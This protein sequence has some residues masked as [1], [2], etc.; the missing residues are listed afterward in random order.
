MICTL[1]PV[2]MN[3]SESPNAIT[4]RLHKIAQLWQDFRSVPE[5]RVCRWLIQ[6]D[7]KKMVDAFLETTYLE[8]NPVT[9]FFLPFYTAFT[10][11]E[12]YSMQLVKELGQAVA[13]DKETLGAEGLPVSWAAEQPEE[14]QALKPAYFLR[15]LQL[16]AEQAPAADLLVAVLLPVA[17]NPK[18]SKWINGIVKS[19]IPSNLRLLIVEQVG[20]ELLAT[21][22]GKFPDQVLDAELRLDMPDAMRQLAAAGNPADPGVQF[23][24]AFLELSQAAATRKLSEI[25][26]LEISPLAI[27]RQQGWAPLEIAVHSLVAS[28][29]IGL[30]RLPEAL[31]RYEQGYNLSQKVPLAGQRLGLTLAVQCLFNKG[32]VLIARK[33]FPEAA[34]TFAQAAAHA[35]EVSDHFQ[36]MEAKR[37]QGHCL[38]KCSKW[39]EAFRVEQEAL[40]SAER[41]EQQVRLNSTLP[42]LGRALLDLAYQLGHK[43]RYLELADK[44]TALAGAGW[45]SKLQT[46]KAPAV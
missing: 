8:S 4:Q 12:S 13:A 38:E 33:A 17:A 10:H 21:A 40:V 24:K 37:M 36:I 44:L 32:S 27:A 29:Y 22:A 7:E 41:L 9:D 6:A 46:V 34:T 42:Y 18:F 39:E 25:K 23:R 28:A 45:Q 43:T 11:P 3:V 14:G 5:A 31:Q 26:R 35:L 15:Q 19:G 30:N 2:T 20:E 16:F 1:I